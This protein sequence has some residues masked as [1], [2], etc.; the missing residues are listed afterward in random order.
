MGLALSCFACCLLASYPLK[1]AGLKAEHQ[2]PTSVQESRAVE[3]RV[4]L[5]GTPRVKEVRVRYRLDGEERY[6]KIK[7][8]RQKQ[9]WLL[10]IPSS[11]VRPPHI[12]YF[13][14]AQSAQGRSHLVFA[15]PQSP[16]QL[17][18]KPVFSSVSEGE[19]Q[20]KA[21]EKVAVVESPEL[22]SNVTVDKKTERQ[23]SQTK[24]L[25]NQLP[26]PEPAVAVEP[27]RLLHTKPR[28]GSFFAGENTHDLA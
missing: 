27:Q 2:P 23:S 21:R 18:I 6:H 13:I 7:G 10:I 17:T 11:E 8:Y 12:E 16:H 24:D 22:I 4:T 25:Q 20:T 9:E 15:S 5:N 14:V 3:L 19:P 1:A 26:S 28:R